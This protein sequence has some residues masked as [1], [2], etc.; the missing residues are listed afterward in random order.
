MLKQL[1]VGVALDDFGTGYSSLSLLRAFPFDRIKLDRSFV[2]EVESS[3]E[4]MG[5]VKAVLALGD[6]LGVAVLAEGIETETQ[7]T[8][9][10]RAGLKE[11]QGYLLGRPVPP[12]KRPEGEGL[13][14]VLEMNQRGRQLPRVEAVSDST[15]AATTGA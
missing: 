8:A 14:V 7:F 15:Q 12:E 5:I 2:V 13:P 1:G 4:A 11:A 3:R 9:L 6:V 10:G